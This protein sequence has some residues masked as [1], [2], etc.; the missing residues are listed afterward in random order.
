MRHKNNRILIGLLGSLLIYS[1]ACTPITQ[2]EADTNLPPESVKAPAEEIA[3][4]VD[5]NV[6]E[7]GEE[8]QTGPKKSEMVTA[9][10]GI[11]PTRLTIPAINVD[12]NINSYGL[13]ESGAMAV[14]ED[15]ETVAW[16]EPGTKPGAKGN[17]V[18]AAHVDDYTGPAIFFYLKDLEIGDEVLVADGDQT[19]T[20]VVTGKEAYP[21]NEAPI[22]TIFGPSN[23]Q[24]L[25]LITC[26]G[27][28]DRKTNN[29]QERL[30]IYTELKE[31]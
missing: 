31:T 26:T 14:P 27:L 23:N 3:S 29:H 30:V 6:N 18:L 20:F 5:E 17:A 28:Y 16:F 12:A 10:Q 2:N 11:I 9:P 4:Q 15:G 21:Y 19:L 13:D 8:N 24:Q 7:P 25:N 1:T 22:R